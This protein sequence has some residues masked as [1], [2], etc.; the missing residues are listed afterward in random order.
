[1]DEFP[2]C[3]DCEKEY[4]DLKDRRC[5]GETICC[6]DCGPILKGIIRGEKTLYKEE[7][8]NKAIDM[9]QKGSIIMAKS[10]GEIKQR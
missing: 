10:I 4:T 2:L 7:A 6:E 9:V 5:H 1:M 3:G 8:M